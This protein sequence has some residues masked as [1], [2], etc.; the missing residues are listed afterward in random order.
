MQRKL[1]IFT[2]LPLKFAQRPT[3]WM[4]ALPAKPRICVKG[5]LLESRA[6]RRSPRL[7]SVLS[8]FC[9]PDT[10]LPVPVTPQAMPENPGIVSREKRHRE[11]KDTKQSKKAPLKARGPG[12]DQLDRLQQPGPR[13][14]EMGRFP[15]QRSVQ[16]RRGACVTILACQSNFILS[17]LSRTRTLHGAPCS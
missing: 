3:P 9:S 8:K 12:S 13:K 4:A 6:R 7:S 14:R 1:H 2:Q 10:H 17:F 11:G 15:Q 5:L 16:G